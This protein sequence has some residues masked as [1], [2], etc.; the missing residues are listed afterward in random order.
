MFLLYFQF[1]LNSRE[2][3]RGRKIGKEKRKC[4]VR[5]SPLAGFT[6]VSSSARCFSSLL[7]R[8]KE[9][10]FL[11]WEEA[12]P[13]SETP[14]FF[15]GASSFF[16]LSFLGGEDPKK[17]RKKERPNLFTGLKADG[18]HPINDVGSNQF[19]LTFA[20]LGHGR[21]L[22]GSVRGLSLPR[23]FERETLGTLRAESI[24]TNT[25]WVQSTT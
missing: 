12:S 8:R 13:F 5:W 25:N 14:W 4:F 11:A 23:L 19:C 2:G 1:G 20:D 6:G 15:R 24:Q 7:K 10:G 21:P 22:G 18:A 17:E 9:E 16:F 3:K